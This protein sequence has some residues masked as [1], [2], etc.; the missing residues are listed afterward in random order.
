MFQRLLNPIQTQS[1]FLFGA[2]G[3]GKSTF[4][5]NRFSKTETLWIDLLNPAVE[6]YYRQT[7][8]ALEQEVAGFKKKPKWVVIDEVQ[9]VPRILD[10]VHGLIEKY[11]MKFVLTG[12]SARKLKRG[13][14]NLLAGRALLNYM[15]PLTHLELN[16][17]F[18]LQDVLG[19]GS[20][21]K[22]YSLKTAKEKEEYLKSYALVYLKEEIQLEQIVR[23]IEPFRDF[24]E[25]SA[26]QSGKLLN[27]NMIAKQVGVD[28]KTIINYFQ[29]L[30]DSMF[31]FYLPAY[32][33]SIRKA[34][35]KHPKFYYFDIGVKRALE[36]SLDSKPAAGT[37]YFGELFEHFVINEIRRIASYNMKDYRLC[38][39]GTTDD[40]E[41]DLVIDRGRSSPIFVEIKSTD[42][43]DETEVRKMAKIT[44]ELGNVKKLYLSQDTHSRKINGVDCLHWRKGIQSI[45]HESK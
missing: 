35:R 10:V 12:S 22:I 40:A 6:D 26:L 44:Q 29:I 30:E 4:L 9:K 21:P 14:S 5:A 41:I 23:K 28:D 20:L 38:Y 2:R 43:I 24:L 36:R 1:Y 11:R 34:Q 32:H 37:S 8:Q 3:T 18:K 13:A 19:F 17:Q 39:F 33:R 16:D 25:V 45:F 15:H 42:Y 7:P 27:A 31:G